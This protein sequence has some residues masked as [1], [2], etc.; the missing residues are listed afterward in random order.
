MDEGT[1][2][3]ARGTISAAVDYGHIM[4]S[5]AMDEVT[6]STDPDGGTVIAIRTRPLFRRTAEE[7]P[8]ADQ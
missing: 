4:M 8:R 5:S 2:P 1:T 6:T 7:T 3:I